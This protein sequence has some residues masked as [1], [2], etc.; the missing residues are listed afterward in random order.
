MLKRGQPEGVDAASGMSQL[1][2]DSGT[3]PVPALRVQEW[4][5]RAAYR[6]SACEA[7]GKVTIVLGS[8]RRAYVYHVQ[9]L[10]LRETQSETKTIL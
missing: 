6:G 8:Y 1:A 3:G 2:P 7:L 10:F 5:S 9:D 4:H